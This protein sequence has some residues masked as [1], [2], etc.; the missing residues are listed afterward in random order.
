V[1]AVLREGQRLTRDLGGSAGTIEIA[2]AV[3]EKVAA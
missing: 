2:E 1:N 3:A